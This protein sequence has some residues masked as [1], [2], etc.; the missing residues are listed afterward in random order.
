MAIKRT[1]LVVDFKNSFLE[2]LKKSNPDM[3]I[4]FQMAED[5]RAAQT[6]ILDLSTSI[7]AIYVS[8]YI[9]RDP[10]WVAV[11][12]TA[13]LN[14]PAV[15]LYLIYEDRKGAK[16][17][18]NEN[19]VKFGITEASR[20]KANIQTELKDVIGNIVGSFDGRDAI[21]KA[22]Q[23]QDRVG[24]EIEAVQGDFVP[25]SAADF[26]SGLNSFFDVYAKTPLG[27]YI[28]LLHAGDSF[29]PQRI[30][31][32][33]NKGVKFFYIRREVQGEYV[34][35]VNHVS[36]EVIHSKQASLET[37]TSQVLNSGEETLKHMLQ[38]GIKLSDLKYAG[39]FVGNVRE[40][41]GQ[42][43][44]TNER[45]DAMSDFVS[46]LGAYQHGVATSMVAGLI[47]NHL[48]I[49]TEKPF[50]VVGMAA[51]F[52]DIGLTNMPSHFQDE[53][54]SKM[55]PEEV[56]LYQTH[57][58]VGSKTL[59]QIGGFEGAV[60]Q[61]IEQH[62]MRIA[63]QGF[64]P[65][66]GTTPV[67]RVA[68]IIGISDEFTRI[69]SRASKDPGVNVISELEKNVFPHFGGSIVKAF[70]Q[71]FMPNYDENAQMGEINLPLDLRKK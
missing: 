53:D 40:L 60:T 8:P 19:L 45:A 29:D 35:Y 15:P 52:H 69:I 26:I 3:D 57:P 43:K 39:E 14:R 2:I 32:Y 47:A 1:A 36:K 34:K 59:K 12:R 63:G 38:N 71:V 37:K 41:I 13:F 20:S 48:Q 27:R 68:E 30:H 55:T 6:T 67:T 5:G 51:M 22:R 54:E 61:A 11:L 24:D 44:E 9:K 66:T 17:L 56:K 4:I 31:S 18:T 70:K 58:M 23:F 50:E 42:I 21:Q 64:P 33:L 10:N 7:A 49:S 25:I 46:N 62:H 28:K 16:R 65:R